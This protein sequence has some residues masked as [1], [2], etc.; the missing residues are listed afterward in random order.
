MVK[1][2][3]EMLH[4]A[5]C[6]DE[7]LYLKA[8][9]EHLQK[10]AASEGYEMFDIHLYSKSEEQKQL[11]A[12][13]APKFDIIFMDIELRGLEMSGIELSKRIHQIHPLTQI[14]FITQYEEY[15]S[16]VYEEKHVYFIH[17]PKMDIYM[18]KALEKAI[19]ELKT[20]EKNFLHINYKRKE[21]YVPV[22]DILYLER[23]K[24]ITTIY[25]TGEPLRYYETGEKL[26]ELIERLGQNFVVCH[27]SY[28]VNVS[29]I[30]GFE[31]RRV[32]IVGEMTIPI[33]NN[34]EEME[35]KQRFAQMFTLR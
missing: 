7:E 8:I 24:R 27:R 26:S 34:S 30:T 13:D 20:E 2:G 21:S 33:G 10:L 18:P 3:K 25:C 15:C 19:K 17:K 32:H 31:K 16:D 14:I 6:E 4:I 12:K 9:Q 11:Y 29:K 5:I 1:R 28:A 35:I 23:N 22:Q